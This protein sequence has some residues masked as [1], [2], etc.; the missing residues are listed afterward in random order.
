MTGTNLLQQKQHLLLC[1][2]QHAI[3]CFLRLVCSINLVGYQFVY[4]FDIL[5]VIQHRLMIPLPIRLEFVS[6]V[7]DLDVCCDLLCTS[8]YVRVE[9]VSSK[10]RTM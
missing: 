1:V 4:V 9:T 7:L 6:P 10:R 2:S 3:A 8:K 5:E